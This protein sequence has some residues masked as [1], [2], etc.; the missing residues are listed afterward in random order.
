MLIPSPTS[1][2]STTLE[3]LF[4][5]TSWT[6]PRSSLSAL[7]VQH[8][9]LLGLKPYVVVSSVPV[10]VFENFVESLRIDSKPRVTPD[11]VDSL[12]QLANEFFL[13]DL[14][15]MC[16]NFSVSAALEAERR[17]FEY[18]HSE[19]KLLTRSLRD[20]EDRHSDPAPPR[21]PKPH[22]REAPPHRTFNATDPDVTPPQQPTQSSGTTEGPGRVDSPCDGV[23]AYLRTKYKVDIF[24]AGIV[25]H[26]GW[27]EYQWGC[28]DFGHRRVD[29]THYT[30]KGQRSRWWVVE[31]SQDGRSWTELDRRAGAEEATEGPFAISTRMECRFIRVTDA[32]FDI[33]DPISGI[34]DSRRLEALVAER[35]SWWRIQMWKELSIYGGRTPDVE[36]EFFGRISA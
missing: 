30:I 5:G 13:S 31:G 24:A 34:Y 12:F 23:L 14:C 32:W 21:S 29:P 33:R 1:T 7:L 10:E 26:S 27:T 3:L 20:R 35:S 28:W 17:E 4:D 19:I 9:T 6:V 15:S 36:M 16:A 8:R 22:P 18:I 2:T 11:N 25:V